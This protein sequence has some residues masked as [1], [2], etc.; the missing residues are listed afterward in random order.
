MNHPDPHPPSLPARRDRPP[1]L[2]E[3][4]YGSTGYANHLNV[5]TYGAQPL[6]GRHPELAVRVCR[7]LH[8]AAEACRVQIF[9]YCLM[10]DHLHLIAMVLPGG[11]RLELF[12][13]SIKVR[14]G[15][16]ARG[17]IKG[18][19]WQ[20][21]FYDHFVRDEEGL[22][23]VCTYVLNNPVRAGLVTDRRDYPFCWLSPELGT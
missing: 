14:S 10:P 21:G 8:E 17:I 4:M 23:D 7:C 20:R 22:R 6:F 3:A 9:C 11:K 13:Q 16:A 19:L 15:G 2:A 5:G 18:P 12:M 1:R